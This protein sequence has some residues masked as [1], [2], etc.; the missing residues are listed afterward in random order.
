MKLQSI[1]GMNDITP[2]NSGAWKLA[3]QLLSKILD[4]YGYQQ[5]RLPIMEKTAV[6][7][8]SIG[9]VTDIVQKEMY[10]F[11]DRNGDSLTLRPEGTAGCVRAILQHGLLNQQN[12]KF[13]YIGPMFRHE[14]PQKGRYRQFHQIGVE[15]FD[16]EGPDIDSE[17]IMM[18]ARMWEVLE[19][20]NLRLEINTLGT[21]ENRKRYSG[22]F[23]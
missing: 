18:T 16:L 8:R 21:V 5:I 12:R 14:R 1:K 4:G 15:V 22:E 9:D 19:L 13:W 20:T 17:L 11:E 10:T 23:F 2:V 3:E 7:E 6:F